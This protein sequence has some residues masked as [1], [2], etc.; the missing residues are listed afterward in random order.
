[1]KIPWISRRAGAEQLAREL[2]RHAAELQRLNASTDA[3]VIT[4]TQERDWLRERNEQLVDTI[5]AFKR[6][7]FGIPTKG[8]IKQAPDVDAGVL[9]RVEGGL[10]KEFIDNAKRDMVAQGVSP[11]DA[12]REARRLREEA[13]SEHP[14]GG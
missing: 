3:R 2:Q 12:E 5:I 4:I 9:A 7:G 8:S 14:V 10:T 6:D 13:V 11:I 1:M